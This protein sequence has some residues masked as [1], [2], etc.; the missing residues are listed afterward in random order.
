[1]S[2]EL[3]AAAGREQAVTDKVLA[4]FAGTADSRLREVMLSLVRHLHAFARDV[5]LSE[6]EW[7]TA[8][9]FL[10]RAGHITDDRRQEFILLSDV[11]GLSMLTVAINEPA[12]PGATEATVFGPFYVDDAPEV[13]LGGDVARGAVGTPC[14]VSGQVRSVDGTPIGGALLHVWG[15]DDDGFYDVQYS[16]DHSAG[17]GWLRVAPDGTYRFWTVL[18]TPY[19]IPHDGPVGDLLTAAGRGPMR[20]AHLHFKVVSPDHRTLITH[21]FVAGDPYLQDDAV[22]GVKDSLVVAAEHH[23]AGPA[24]DGSHPRESWASMHFDL[25]LV[26]DEDR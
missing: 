14:Y 13:P 18:P 23:R 3:A 6:Q 12:E 26:S 20:P 24:P 2:R 4:S 15:A 10:T 19:P 1:M 22:F 7:E 25:V 11:L 5:R 8:I 16:A 21:I 17:R 9:E